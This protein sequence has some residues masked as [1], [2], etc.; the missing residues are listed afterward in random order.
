[1][2]KSRD[3]LTGKSYGLFS[4]VYSRF[5]YR[6]KSV[7][8]KFSSFSETKKSIVLNG[9]STIGIHHKTL[10]NIKNSKII[11]NEGSLKVGI[12]FGY[13][14]GGIY[15]SAKDRC[16]IF[17]INSTL[18]IHGNV[19]LYPGVLIYAINAHIIIRNNTKINGNV[20]IIS[21]KKIDIGEDCLFAEGIIVRD[22]DGHKFGSA[23]S[24]SDELENKEIKIGNHCWIGQRAMIL[25]GV[26]LDTN[27]IV[28]A[29]AV[30]A[31]SFQSNVAVAGIPAKIIKENVSWSA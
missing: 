27:V 22:N 4:A 29:G 25:K 16:K 10:I 1:M 9:N 21:L 31:G 20:E 2:G 11:V 23:G 12:D 17:M 19:S 6:I 26:T 3:N 18:E 5:F 30:V 7:Y 14:D 15:D 24:I 13:F 28:G 8:N